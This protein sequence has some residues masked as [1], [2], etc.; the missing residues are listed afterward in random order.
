MKILLLGEGDFSFTHSLVRSG[1]HEF[2]EKVFGSSYSKVSPTTVVATSLDTRAE[3]LRKYPAFV[4]YEKFENLSIHHGVN[5]LDRVKLK[6]FIDTPSIVSWNHPHLG[7]ENCESHYQLLVHFFD[8]MKTVFPTAVIVLSFLA[9]QISR[10]QVVKAA[11]SYTVTNIFPF[12]ES[13]FPGYVCRRSLGGDSFKS[14]RTRA[15]WDSSN[16]VSHFMI[17]SNSTETEPVDVES[18]LNQQHARSSSEVTALVCEKC[19]SKFKSDQGLRTHVRQVHELGL[20]KVGEFKCDTCDRTFSTEES[21]KMHTLNGH[22]SPESKRRK[23]ELEISSYECNLC[24]SRDPDHVAQFGQ[25]RPEQLL[26]CVECGKDFK[27]ERALSQ[28]KNV[29]H[30]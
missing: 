15:N 13:D 25:N 6:S 12:H 16:L 28:H 21:L 10:W 7:L 17:F 3:I 20:Y 26:E 27:S 8:T 1:K 14:S 23:T 9:D 18:Y 2:L 19:G 29:V 24:G 11:G 4:H 30:L 22:M 5:A